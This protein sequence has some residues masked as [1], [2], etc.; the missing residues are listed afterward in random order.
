M[1]IGA[2]THTFDVL[3][4][5]RQDDGGGGATY[6]ETVVFQLRLEILPLAGLEEFS[7]QQL[8]VNAT[9]KMMGHWCASLKTS[10]WLRHRADGRI[11]DIQEKIN[12]RERNSEMVLRCVQRQ[13]A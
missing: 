3:E 7:E 6:A 8:Q 10:Q 9:H 4:K 13:A 1:R 2:L 11:F 12:V 5:T